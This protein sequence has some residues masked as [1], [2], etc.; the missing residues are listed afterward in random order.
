MSNAT[1]ALD[2]AIA[3]CDRLRALLKLKRAVQVWGADERA[4]LKASALT[5]FN[6]HR[7]PVITAVGLDNVV[8][9]D[10][11]YKEL[12]AAGDKAAS[13][14]KLLATIKSTRAALI[15]IRSEAVSAAP[16]TASTDTAPSFAPLI[17]DPQMQAILGTRWSECMKCLAANAPLAATVMMGGLLE[18]ILLARINREPNKGPIFTAT[19]APKDKGGKTK[20]LNEWMLKNYIEV[21]HERGW[22]SVSAKDVGEVL[23]DYR[24]FVHPYKQL[25]QG[26]QLTD[27][28]AKLLW[29]ITKNIM[30]Q[31]LSNAP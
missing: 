27:E 18:A 15:S 25:T 10:A 12:L 8:A 11:K 6:S 24:N 1:A 17:A 21:V 23:R 29:E 7:A 22:I 20:P 30:R 5:W 19:V 13:R 2:G 28:D 14:S 31:V 16:A 26:V 3:Q 9:L 4:I